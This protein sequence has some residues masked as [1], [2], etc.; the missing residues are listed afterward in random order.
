VCVLYKLGGVIASSASALGVALRT[1]TTGNETV[2]FTVFAADEA[3]G[4]VYRVA[5][6][7]ACASAR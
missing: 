3:G 4:G 1:D 5:S 2:Y 6:P 7:A